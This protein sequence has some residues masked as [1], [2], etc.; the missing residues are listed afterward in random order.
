VFYRF[1]FLFVNAFFVFFFCIFLFVCKCP[2]G[3]IFFS[4]GDA[5]A[6]AAV[7]EEVAW[8]MDPRP[9][10]RDDRGAPTSNADMGT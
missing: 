5:G 6:K 1:V 4:S 8:R 9:V 3:N 10:A 2:S 7:F